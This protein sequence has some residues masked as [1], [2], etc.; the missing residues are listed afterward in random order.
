[1]IYYYSPCYIMVQCTHTHTH[2]HTH[3]LHAL[4]TLVH[5]ML[6]MWGTACNYVNMDVCM[7]IYVV[8]NGMT[9]CIC[10][11]G[12]SSQAMHASEYVTL[13][14]NLPIITSKLMKVLTG[15]PSK[16]V[17]FSGISLPNTF[18]VFEK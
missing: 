1:M 5:D 12:L 11:Q 9:L 3:T 4:F 8:A 17:S 10:F 6:Y 15:S 2:T 16:T 14:H 13:L 7:L 18:A